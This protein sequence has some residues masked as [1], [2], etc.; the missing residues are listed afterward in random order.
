MGKFLISKSRREGTTG[1]L[2]PTPM[3][4]CTH[5][6]NEA[7]QNVRNRN[8]ALSGTKKSEKTTTRGQRSGVDDKIGEGRRCGWKSYLTEDS[9][10][11]EGKSNREKHPFAFQ[12]T[13]GRRKKSLLSY[14]LILC[15]YP[16]GPVPKTQSPA[17]TVGPR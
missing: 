11:T 10:D 15:C 12:E 13:D 5:F 8:S 14:F 4:K 7:K 1:T 16:K 9:S 2:I 6:A 3:P 17:A